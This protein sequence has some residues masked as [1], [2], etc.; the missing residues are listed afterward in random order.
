MGRYRAARRVAALVVAGGAAWMVDGAA[1]A[2]SSHAGAGQVAQAAAHSFAIPAQPLVPALT[3]FAQQSGLQ[4]VYAA[5][6]ASGRRSAGV[7]GTMSADD[8]LARLLAGTGLSARRGAG[9]VVIIESAAAG[10]Q[11]GEVLSLAP[12]TVTGERVDRSL[13]DTASSVAI[14]DA[15]ALESRAGVGTTNEVLAQIPNVVASE[16]SNLAPAIRGLD[17]TGP[18][19]GANAFFAGV[20]PRLTM[21]VDG[22]PLGFNEL[23]FGNGSLWDT[24]QVEVFRGPQSTIQGRNSI[25]GAVVVKTN[26]PTYFPEGALRLQGGQ[27]EERQGSAM[28]SGPIV[29]DQLALRVAVDHR[30]MHSPIDFLGYPGIDD[31][32]KYE[33]TTLRGKLLIEP[34]RIEGFSSLLTV[35]HAEHRGPQTE[36]VARPYE[37]GTASYPYQPVFAPRSTSGVLESTYEI[38]DGL[39][40]KNTASVA[41]TSVRRYALPGDGNV[42]IDGTEGLIEPRLHMTA[43]DGRLKSFVGVYAFRSQ[44]DESIDLFG[45]GNFDDST[46]TAALFGEATLTVFDDVDVTMG[47]RLEQES[48]RRVGATGPFVLDFDETYT[49]FLPKAGVAWH[50]TDQLTVGATVTRGYNGGGAGFTY[51]APFVSFTYDPEYVWNYEAYARADLMGGRLGLTGNVFFSDYRDMQL[52]FS[53][54]QFSTV[55]RNADRAHTYGAELGARWQATPEWTLHGGI[56]LLKTEITEYPDSGLEGNELPRSPAF[57]TTAGVVYRSPDGLTASVDARYTSSY[58]TEV[59]NPAAGEAG[60]WWT[61][62]ARVGYDFGGAEAYIYGTNLFDNDE[63]VLIYPQFDAT[64]Q[65]PRAVGVGVKAWF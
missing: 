29:D 33:S 48:R 37:D 41:A 8:A 55:I 52:P 5:E 28:I 53:L 4:L 34:Q 61:V 18:A 47:G 49:E 23:I 65:R 19:E 57:T 64:L 3:A 16:P 54:S 43:L 11:S 60:P 40:L 50:A 45:G 13:R 56:G 24:E 1:K 44:Q 21:Q 6:L 59:T 39:T 51:E 36:G 31:P 38:A 12:V 27:L 20:R 42:E 10:T 15:D 17:S 62:N 32:G 35:T 14:Y 26:D 30:R 25:A 2:D 63:P 9:D 7:T 46:S 22:R 58:H